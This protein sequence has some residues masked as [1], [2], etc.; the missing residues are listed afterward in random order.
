MMINLS[1]HNELGHSHQAQ[2]YEPATHQTESSLLSML[3]TAPSS[4]S[5]FSCNGAQCGKKASK[6]VIA[7]RVSERRVHSK[8]NTCL[9]LVQ[10]ELV[11][12]SVIHRRDNEGH[13][14]EWL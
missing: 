5:T 14:D 3:T 12:E 9:N 13:S 2:G 10:S 7:N 4:S 6:G 8:T 11:S 1:F